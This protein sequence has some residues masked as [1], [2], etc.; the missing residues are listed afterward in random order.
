VTAQ[1]E[2]SSQVPPPRL[3]VQPQQVTLFAPPEPLRLKCGRTLENVQV[4]YE[5]YGTL[6][7]DKS[8]AV[9]IFHALTGDAHVAG[10]H[11]EHDNKPGWWDDMVGPGTYIDTDKYFVICAN[12][13]GGCRGT[14]GHGDINPQTGRRWGL[15]F[16]VITVEDMVAVHKALIDHLGI[17]QLLTV[18]G[19][20]MGG[21]LA[22]EW[23]VRYPESSASA[24]LIATTPR[25]NAQ[26]IAFDA[27]G[28][29]AI[30][31]DPNFNDGQYNDEAPPER[32]LSIARMVGHITYLSEQGMHEKFGRQLRNAKRYNYDFASEFSVET[33]LDYQGRI[34]V[35][36]FDANSYLYISKAL[37]Y[38]DLGSRADSLAEAMA[39]VQANCLVISFSGDWLFPPAQ[40]RMIVDALLSNDQ[41]VSYCEL[42]SPYG[43]DAFLLETNTLGRMIRGFLAGVA[44]PPIRDRARHIEPYRARPI[45]Q[46]SWTR[47]RVDYDRIEAIIPERARVLDL[48]CGHGVLLSQLIQHKQVEGLGVEVEQSAICDCIDLGLPVVDLDIEAE[49]ASFASQSYDY[50]VLS[51]TLQTLHKPHIVLRE[52]VRVGRF[53]IV[54]FPN[55]VH[56]RPI[57]QMLLTG[58]TPLTRKLPFW[59]YDSPNVRSLTIR[60]FELWCRENNIR[61][62]RRIT[63]GEGGGEV[64]HVLPHIRAAEAVFV[65][66]GAS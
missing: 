47:Q 22:L 15:D 56:W 24:I 46:P 28:R 12:N 38:Y 51:Q 35:E 31:A 34:F 64:V 25:L 57:L 23:I 29:N 4:T 42:N 33:Y 5:T 2:T 14:T 32:G 9:L 65:I 61:I 41:K 18:V 21:M 58:R 20:S 45:A 13:L 30:L 39:G 19:G 66:A 55:F 7:A 44:G 60:D 43:H 48:G 37:D 52:M 26:G 10:Y 16:P 40:S 59:W 36:R 8:N 11:N 1:Q 53:G 63:L 49:L 62:V 50:V 54:S 27:V 3:I 6:N 17:D